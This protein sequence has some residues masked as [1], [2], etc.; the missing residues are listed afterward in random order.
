MRVCHVSHFTLVIL[1]DSNLV[2]DT[3]RTLLRFAHTTPDSTHAPTELS[4]KL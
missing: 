1:S 3:S 4:A 2:L